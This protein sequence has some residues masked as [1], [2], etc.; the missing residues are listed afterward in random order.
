M[1][2]A[3]SELLPGL[4]EDIA[5]YITGI[6]DDDGALED[7]DSVEDTTAMIAGLL[8]EYCEET[9]E[10]PSDKAEALIARC[11]STHKNNGGENVAMTTAAATAAAALPISKLGGMSLAD[12][13]KNNDNDLFYGDNSRSTV[14]TIIE[15]TDDTT[16]TTKKKS[17]NK[18][19]KKP[20][21]SEIA[22][23]QITEIE[24]ELRDAR[25]AAV[26]ARAKYGAYKGSLDAK[27]FTL[28]NPGGGAPLLEDA[29]CRLVWGKRYGELWW[30][31]C[32]C[33][34]CYLYDI[35]DYMELYCH[36]VI[37][38]QLIIMYICYIIYI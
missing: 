29:A 18:N 25:V 30:W 20:T 23:A 13:L 35:R 14:N 9:E 12:Q 16:T 33:C 27:A 1:S 22:N 7:A 2:S 10:D 37:S 19:S 3:I 4:D 6:L 26:R 36:V 24:T 38:I 32:C 31:W 11:L 21:A 15:E 17:S 28:P 5:E 34:A 8:G